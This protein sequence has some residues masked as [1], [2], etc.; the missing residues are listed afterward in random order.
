MGHRWRIPRIP[1][2]AYSTA[3]SRA[4]L[5]C[6]SEI[7]RNIATGCVSNRWLARTR[8]GTPGIGA[9]GHRAGRRFKPQGIRA[10]QAGHCYADSS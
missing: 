3:I 5:E 10:F 6:P 4:K 8:S 1:S 9:C 2:A 7:A